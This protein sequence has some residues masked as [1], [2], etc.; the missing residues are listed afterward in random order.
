[1][2]KLNVKIGADPEVFMKKVG[3]KL[4]G[5]KLVSAYGAIPGD[6]EHPH[7]VKNGAVQVD[8]MALE[9]NIDP[10]LD[11]EHFVTNIN[12]VMGTL[13]RMIPEGHVLQPVPTA[14]FG[15]RYMA[16]QPKEAVE[17]GCDPDYNA[18]D[19]GRPN[20]KPDEAADFR[21]GAGHI[22]IGWTEDVDPLH[23]EHMEA[24]IILAKQLDYYLAL[25]SMR[26]DKDDKRRQLYGA[27]GAFRPKPYGCEY[28]TL[29][30]A[31]LKNDELK[32][33][34]YR[35]TIK[36]IDDLMDRKRAANHWGDRVVDEVN[37]EHSNQFVCNVIRHLDIEDPIIYL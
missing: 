30:N 16:Q 14:N 28:R 22:H 34:V 15:A 7:V 18:W 5:G 12:S 35:T 26:F 25:P 37:G 11:E 36:A 23:P 10:A 4:G 2:N 19:G 24:C 3:A 29:S 21:T 33:W 9:F 17:M 6:K 27:A 13:R 20:H 32:A 1:M 31:W 8:G